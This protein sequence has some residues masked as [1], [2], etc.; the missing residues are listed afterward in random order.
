MAESLLE[1]AKRLNIQPASTSE[2]LLDKAKR[3]GI[4]PAG[5][6]NEP[7][8][9]QRV[10]Q[11][12][13]QNLADYTTSVEQGGEALALKENTARGQLR[14]TTGLLRPVLRAAGAAANIAQNAVMELPGIKQATEFVAGNLVKAPGAEKV[15]QKATDL[16]TKYP[17][18][19]K[20]IQ[21]IVDIVSL[22]YAPK[23]AGIVGKEAKAIGSDIA[24]AGK[25]ALN[26]SEE[27]V[28]A[29]IID[30]FQKS[31]KPSA[32]KT[33]AQGEKY[34]N[35]IIKS[36]KTIKSNVDQLNIEDDVG[37]LIAG[38]TPQTLSELSQAVDQTKKLVFDQYDA[39]AKEAG[40]GGAVVD[41]KPIADE[42]LKVAQNKA[43]QI[44]NPELIKYAE[45]WAERLNGLGTIDTETAQAI[46]QNLNTSLSAFYRNPTYDAATKVSIDAGIVNNF[47]KSLD[48]A[49]EGATG[50]EYQSLKN[51]YSALKS[52]ENDVVRAANRDARKN[53]KG[54]LDYSDIFTSG[55]MVGGI[56]SL[57]PAMFTKGAVERGFKEYFKFL[58]DPNRAVSNMFDL[59]DTA[60]VP[61]FTPKSATFNSLKNPK[62]QSALSGVPMVGGKPDDMS[63]ERIKS[64]IAFRESGIFKEPYN[65]VNDKNKNGTADYGKYQVNEKT[66]KTYGK[67]FLGKEVTPKEFLA[68]PGL[69]EQFVEGA[70]K[71]LQSKGAKSL[72]AF[73]ALWHKGWGDI[74]TKRV[75]SLKEDPGVKKYLNNKRK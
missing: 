29:D 12:V 5:K 70:I 56:L 34:E 4:E 32:Q 36:L 60:D 48:E 19:A 43:L 9:F 63:P 3:L 73:L 44:T 21:N 74:S 54:L 49:I 51:E 8:Y 55:Q 14:A 69:Q 17:E 11:N 52:I 64:E 57:N 58:N 72:D 18:Q 42:V 40:T 68:S 27:A 45:Q 7:N 65:A 38:R 13:K 25:V 62:Q 1:K 59:L 16:A 37:E 67:K 30:M 2:S 20:D 61:P 24:Q 66:L 75:Q 28:Q 10:G 41:A 71:H 50:K 15:I 6:I 31:I 26:S 23:V 53:A 46:V 39:L 35:N 47:R 33:V 22:G